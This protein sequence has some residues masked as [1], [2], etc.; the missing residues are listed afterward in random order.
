MARFGVAL[1]LIGDF[2]CAFIKATYQFTFTSSECYIG[3]IDILHN[4]SNIK[5]YIHVKHNVSEYGA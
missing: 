5:S 4:L 1:A 3:L 2:K